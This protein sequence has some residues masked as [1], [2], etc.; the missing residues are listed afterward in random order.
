MKVRT[1]PP[2]DD[3]V[4]MDA[5]VWAGLIPLRM[6]VGEPVPDE[7]TG[8]TTIPGHVAFWSRGDR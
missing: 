3:E 2:I 8:D 4:D 1:G 5:D 6:G 7:A